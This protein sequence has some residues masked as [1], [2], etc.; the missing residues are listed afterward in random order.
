MSHVY[1]FT[2]AGPG[3]EAHLGKPLVF[4]HVSHTIEISDASYR[5]CLH[6]GH[7]AHCIRGCQLRTRLRYDT[8][9]SADRYR[10]YVQRRLVMCAP[11]DPMEYNERVHVPRPCAAS[12]S[13]AAWRAEA[14]CRGE[15]RTAA[16]AAAAL[17]CRL[18]SR[19]LPQPVP[20]LLAAA[21]PGSGSE[22]CAPAPP[23][24]RSESRM[25]EGDASRNCERSIDRR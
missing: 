20:T 9:I 8:H 4:F 14:Q 15:S 5:Y 13:S 21:S 11:H 23:M 19:T 12:R 24:R 6:N 16:T 18:S 10:L 1:I 7:I 3:A 17:P 22:S 25:L 2:H